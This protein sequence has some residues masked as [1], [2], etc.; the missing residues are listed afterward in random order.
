MT[1]PLP[2]LR[3]W[4]KALLLALGAFLPMLIVGLD[5]DAL[6]LK[7][8]LVAVNAAVV[9]L[10]ATYVKPAGKPAGDDT[11]LRGGAWS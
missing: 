6:T 4:V 9:V 11:P 2:P 8:W 1:S 7:E 3:T 10:V 5:D